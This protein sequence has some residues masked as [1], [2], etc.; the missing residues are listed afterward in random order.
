MKEDPLLLVNSLLI[1]Y[2]SGRRAFQVLP[3]LNASASAGELIA[4]IGRNGIGKSTLLRTLTGLQPALGGS[5][6]LSGKEISEYSRMELARK[7]GYISTEVVRTGSMSVYD[8]VALGRF[9]HTNWIGT[10]DIDSRKAITEAIR[11]SGMEGFEFRQVAEL[12]DGERQRAM[13]A[14]VLAQDAELMIM[15]EPTAFLDIAGRY[16]ITKLA[17]DLTR[18]GKTIIYS[19]HDLNPALTTTDK[20]WLLFKDKLIEGTSDELISNGSFDRLFESSP[21]DFSSMLNRP[22]KSDTK[23]DYLKYFL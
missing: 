8:L 1:G 5:I 6:L 13:I 22:V 12:S 20:I 2:S 21:I 4:V 15:D 18:L 11:K 7:I 16:E 23:G 9:P 10:L 17:Y 19:T 3:E 14:R